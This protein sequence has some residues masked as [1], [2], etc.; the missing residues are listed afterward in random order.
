M[1]RIERLLHELKYEVQLGILQ[2]EI[3]PWIQ[4]QYF[5]PL[6][7]NPRRLAMVTFRCAVVDQFSSSTRFSETEEVVG[8]IEGTK[9]PSGD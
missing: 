6:M 7:D 2:G 3:E 1:E 9:G 4:H 8:L 5:V